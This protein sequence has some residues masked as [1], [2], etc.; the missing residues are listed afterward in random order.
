LTASQRARALRGATFIEHPALHGTDEDLRLLAQTIGVGGSR[1]I[2]VV[3]AALES[4]NQALAGLR[5]EF[6]VGLPLAVLLAT[7]GALW[8]ASAALRPVQALQRGAEAI[9]RAGPSA[10][11]AEP[12]SRDEIGELARTLNAMLARIEA[13]GEHE[14]RFVADASHELRTPLALVQS[15]LEVTLRGPQ[16]LSS[17]RRALQV[18]ERE[19]AGLAQLAKDLLLLARADDDRLTLRREPLEPRT[20]LDSLV[21][22]FAQRA[23]AEN[24]ALHVQCADEGVVYVDRPRLEQALGNL[25][26]N[27]LRHGSGDIHVL[28]RSVH[29]SVE[30]AVRDAGPG[31]PASFA[32]RAFERFTRADAARSGPG[33]GLGLAIVDS[34]A[35]AHGGEPYIEQDATHCEVGL[36]VP[37]GVAPS[38]PNE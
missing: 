17:Y 11:L 22:Q 37:S 28:A 34:V 30:F 1:R 7:A 36:R 4:R 3:G 18:A 16:S 35:R 5:R 25:I 12:P 26:E 8:L 38:V 23:A 13:A 2:V 19:V 9:T 29:G 10:R 15:E 14:R 33:A 32:G 6:T 20:L 21:R 27:A 24:R 31:M